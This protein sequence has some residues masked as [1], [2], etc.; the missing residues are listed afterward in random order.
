MEDEGERSASPTSTCIEERSRSATRGC[1]GR[2]ASPSMASGRLERWSGL[3]IEGFCQR[4][5]VPL[6]VRATSGVA[7]I[8]VDG[9][10]SSGEATSGPILVSSASGL[11]AFVLFL[12]T[13]M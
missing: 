8:G 10:S 2:R 6:E 4:D 3:G 11:L 1:A 13:M 9:A 12:V 7:E 5:K